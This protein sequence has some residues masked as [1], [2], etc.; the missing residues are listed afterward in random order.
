MKELFP[1]A[2][3]L[4]DTH[5]EWVKSAEASVKRLT[6][7]DVTV[8]PYTMILMTFSASVRFMAVNATRKPARHMSLRSSALDIQANQTHKFSPRM[9]CHLRCS[10]K[11]PYPHWPSVPSSLVSTVKPRGK[12]W[13]AIT[14]WGVSPSDVRQRLKANLIRTLSYSFCSR[15]T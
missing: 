14:T 4:H 7:P 9:L 15:T 11:V 8:E 12:G 13:K 10:L 3:E 6:R 2:D 5:A 1:D